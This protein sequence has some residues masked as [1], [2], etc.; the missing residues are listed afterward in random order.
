MT[1]ATLPHH[2]RRPRWSEDTTTSS[3]EAVSPVG[4]PLRSVEPQEP[5]GAA[6]PAVI[7]SNARDIAWP[8]FKHHSGEGIRGNEYVFVID[9]GDAPFD[10]ASFHVTIATEVAPFLVGPGSL[11]FTWHQPTPLPPS[12]QTELGKRLW[13]IRQQIIASGLPTLDWS[14]VEREVRTRRGERE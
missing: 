6:R 14:G 8:V 2:V 7:R 5:T 13:A 10:F 4:P 3:T 1:L 11:A 9:P 12:F